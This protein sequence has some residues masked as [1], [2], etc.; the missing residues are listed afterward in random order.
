MNMVYQKEKAKRDFKF[1][2]ERTDLQRNLSQLIKSMELSNY[3][4]IV[5]SILLAGI[6][7]R[8]VFW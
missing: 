8:L 1:K 6:F 3:L 2:E 4:L 5:I 7:L